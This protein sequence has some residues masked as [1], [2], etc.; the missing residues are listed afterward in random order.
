M[1]ITIRVYLLHCLT[2]QIFLNC[3]PKQLLLKV[4]KQF[5]YFEIIQFFLNQNLVEELYIKFVSQKLNKTTKVKRLC[6]EKF[7]FTQTILVNK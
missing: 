4:L 6:V 2:T 3:L 7:T 1:N 5:E